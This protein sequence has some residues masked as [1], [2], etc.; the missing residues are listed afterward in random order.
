MIILSIM[1]YSAIYKIATSLLQALMYC[2]TLLILQVFRF[3]TG[4]LNELVHILRSWKYFKHNWHKESQQHTFTVFQPRL[5]LAELHPLEGTIASMLTADMWRD[6]K[7]GE[8][9]II[10][11]QYVL[12][13]GM[14]GRGRGRE[15]RG[16]RERE[17]E[18]GER[19]REGG[20]EGGS[21][22]IMIMWLNRCVLKMLIWSRHITCKCTPARSS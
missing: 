3:K 22:K 4:G 2:I 17:R 15:R 13:V 20:R 19:E 8:G 11:K 5:S 7:D 21:E 9:R 16:K 10:D 6:L 12:K 14:M 1:Y 18:G